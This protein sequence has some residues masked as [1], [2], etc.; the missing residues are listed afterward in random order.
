MKRKIKN[1]NY[2]ILAFMFIVVILI[3]MYICKWITLYKEEKIAV[4]PLVDV[5][6]K[7]ELNEL[8][9]AT[10]EIND[11]IIYFGYTN[12]TE[13]F[14]LDNRF[15]RVIERLNIEDDFFYVNV[16]DGLLND[17]YI[18]DIV[19]AYPELKRQNIKAPLLIYTKGG[20]ALKIKSSIK[21]DIT[22]YDLENLATLLETE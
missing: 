14:A 8:P 22:V 2:V 19:V 20:N 3:T 1:K 10:S 5:V 6:S 9:E 15:K 16:N 17:K 11:A 18:D 21:K 13:M 4:S 7:I 12:D